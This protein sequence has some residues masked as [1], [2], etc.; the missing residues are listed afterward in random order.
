[1]GAGSVANKSHC[2]LDSLC[3][4]DTMAWPPEDAVRDGAKV[5]GGGVGRKPS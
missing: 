5:T 4:C 3:E 2:H 1:L